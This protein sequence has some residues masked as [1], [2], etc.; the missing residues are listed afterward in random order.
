MQYLEDVQLGRQ[1][2]YHKTTLRFW[3]V[4]HYHSYRLC[5][6]T[7]ATT[8]L[9]VPREQFVIANTLDDVLQVNLIDQ[10]VVLLPTYSVRMPSQ[11]SES[12]STGIVVVTKSVV[13]Y[14]KTT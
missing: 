1:L 5:Q 7:S 12:V 9:T 4:F 14:D 8:C 2:K 11:N 13:E 6:I 10:A 3:K